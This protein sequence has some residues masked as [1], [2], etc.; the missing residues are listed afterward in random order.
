MKP[1]P[2]LLAFIVPLS[3]VVGH[4][5]GGVF[6]F[7]TPVIAFVIIPLLD[8]VA[9]AEGNNLP[10][11]ELEKLA[12]KMS[13]RV[14]TFLYVPVQVG[15]VL[16]GGY[17]VTHAA[18]TPVEWLGLVVSVGIAT[19]G[20]GITVAHELFHKKNAFEKA[21]GHV[22]LLTVSYMHFAL[23]HLIGHHVNVATPRDPATARLGESVYAFYPRTVI[24]SWRSAWDFERRRLERMGTPLWS[25]HNRMLWFAALPVLFAVLLGG[26]LG[27]PAV[28]YFFAQSVVGFTLL[29]IVN[30]LEHYGLQRR[31]LAPGR[32]E[33]VNM[34]HAWNADQRITNYFL[35]KLQRHA[36]HHVHPQRRYQ[37]LRH[38]DESPQLPTGYA[39]MMLL[40]LVPPLWR[41]VMHPR[42][43][44]FQRQQSR[45]GA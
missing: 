38:F 30:Y 28:P 40:A 44:A 36:D 20:I 6:H 2:Y 23:E 43:A 26:I 32:Y 27:W 45:A 16:W 24:N 10:P 12:E 37:T 13:F 41:A 31:E 9:G 5:W 7:L 18:L 21:L 22:L 34:T 11:A 17:V 19:G 4:W 33:R 15:L 1:W 35:F 25:R 3:A 39:G 42:L 29:E 14:I 8:L